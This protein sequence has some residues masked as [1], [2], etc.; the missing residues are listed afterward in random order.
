MVV[1]THLSY[2]LRVNMSYQLGAN[3]L[4][5]LGQD[6]YCQLYAEYHGASSV[7]VHR[8]SSTVMKCASCVQIVFTPVCASSLKLHAMQWDCASLVEMYC[9]SYK[10]NFYLSCIYRSVPAVCG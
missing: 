2:Q 4:S 6:L 10:L 1:E 7:C 8:A 9:A 3:T 5:Q